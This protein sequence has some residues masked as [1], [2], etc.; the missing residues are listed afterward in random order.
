[1]TEAKYTTSAKILKALA[2]ILMGA[3]MIL[4]MLGFSGLWMGSIPGL[5]PIYMLLFGFLLFI[6]SV[7]L[8]VMA[9]AGLIKP[10]FDSISLLKC[11]NPECKFTKGNKFE[12]DDYVFKKLEETCDKCNSTLYIAAIF[13]VERKPK[14]EE[15]EKEDSSED[16][17]AQNETLPIEEKIPKSA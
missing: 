4:I 12:K 2:Y 1:M 6:A 10:E 17:E 13:E 11:T 14:K 15:E 5:D 16:T 8:L 3:A 9:Q 7:P